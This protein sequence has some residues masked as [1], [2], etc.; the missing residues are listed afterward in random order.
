MPAK[1]KSGSRNRALLVFL[2]GEV[3]VQY[4]LRL[5]H[6]L[7]DEDLARKNVWVAGYANDVMAYIP[8]LQVLNEGG[9]EGAS[10]MVYYGLPTT[11]TADVEEAVVG[12][13]RRQMTAK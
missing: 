5:K 2:G 7:G 10:A 1:K 9:Y 8:S 13:V 11:W 4:P 3:T 12:E 6:E